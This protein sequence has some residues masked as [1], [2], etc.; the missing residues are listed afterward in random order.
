[1]AH[2]PRSY[3]VHLQGRIVRRNRRHSLNTMRQCLSLILSL[4]SQGRLHCHQPQ[5]CTQLVRKP[6]PFTYRTL[7]WPNPTL[8]CIM[9]Q[10]NPDTFSARHKQS[11]LSL[12][13]QLSAFSSFEK[14]K[15]KKGSCILLFIGY[16]CNSKQVIVS[17]LH[18]LK[19]GSCAIS[20]C[21][22][23]QR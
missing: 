16:Y 7:T 15:I 11:T 17:V 1:M 4:F 9:G 2:T 5:G 22:Y 21:A 12:V 13:G 20:S 18:S 23:M 19:K 14:T 8:G 10:N 6:T 3:L